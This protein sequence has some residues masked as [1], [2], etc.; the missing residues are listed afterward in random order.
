MVRRRWRGTEYTT[1]TVQALSMVYAVSMV[2]EVEKSPPGGAI[3]PS[4]D[5]ASF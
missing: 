5:V 3:L 2:V 1:A 4:V